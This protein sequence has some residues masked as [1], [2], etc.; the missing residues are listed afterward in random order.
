MN[1]E[2]IVPIGVAVVA[3]LAIAAALTVAW[4]RSSGE[5]WKPKVSRETLA[6]DKPSPIDI[7]VARPAPTEEPVA[8][9]PEV[10]EPLERAP[11]AVAV[12]VQ[13]APRVV[14]VSSEEAGVT[15]RSFLNRALGITFLG[16]ILGTQALAYLAFLWPK[17]SGGFGSDVVAGKATDLMGQVHNADGTV[18]PAF[19]PEA[20]AYI[21][22]GPPSLSEQF[23]GQSVDAEG[24]MALYQRCVHL[25]CRVPWCQTSQGFEC[26]C[27]GSK[28]NG[29][30]EYFAGPAPR[31]LDRFV[32]ELADNGDFIVK[33]GTIIETPRAI[34]K[35]VEYPLGPSCL[36]G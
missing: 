4:R 31:N 25:G 35:S 3:I 18:T 6:S 36:G 29:V 17:I 28:Y 30:G 8:E 33:T 19:I 15:R 22:P 23:E 32:V 16:G 5:E 1:P 34:D 11:S 12:A 26:P 2:M 27:H 10:A 21:V 14:E 20:R 24:L 13:E 7:S 9:K